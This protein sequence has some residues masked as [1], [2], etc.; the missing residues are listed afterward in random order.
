MLSPFLPER[1]GDL[2]SDPEILQMAVEIHRFINLHENIELMEYASTIRRPA[3]EGIVDQLD[4]EFG[5]S[6]FWNEAIDERVRSRLKQFCGKVAADVMDMRH[7]VKIEGK[8]KVPVRQLR[9]SQPKERIYLFK[10]A[11]RFKKD[12]GQEAS[13]T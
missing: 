8:S 7:W 4:S 3:V 6:V 5:E 2:S 12:E 11:A 13:S 1:F 10:T 9:R